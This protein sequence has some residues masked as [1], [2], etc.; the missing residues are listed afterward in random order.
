MCGLAVAIGIACS[1]HA[2][3]SVPT[4]RWLT[5]DDNDGKP[6][7]LVVI[8]EKQGELSGRIE[9]IFPRPRDNGQNRCAKCEGARRNQPVVGMVFLWGLRNQGDEYSGGQILDPDNGKIYRAKLRMSPDGK[10]L[11]VRGYIGFSLF[12]RSQTWLREK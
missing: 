10:Q 8:E 4:G 7:S 5:L 3:D 6:R 11:I 9:Q 1:A 12:G 2:V